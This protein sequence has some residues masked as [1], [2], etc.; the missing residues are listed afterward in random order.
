M[1]VLPEKNSRDAFTAQYPHEE[2]QL[3]S[4]ISHART[5]AAEG[6]VGVQGFSVHQ[7]S[8][9]GGHNSVGLD[10]MCL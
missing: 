3:F 8:F 5:K 4:H 1:Y 9:T 10:L 7:R 2:G 6:T